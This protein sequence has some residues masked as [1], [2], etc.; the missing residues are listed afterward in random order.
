MRSKLDAIQSDINMIH[1]ND[2]YVPDINE[3][4]QLALRKLGNDNL[5]IPYSDKN[6]NKRCIEY[7]YKG[8]TVNKSNDETW[9]LLQI[10]SRALN[11]RNKDTAS[12]IDL[13]KK[14]EGI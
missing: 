14:L 12:N 8:L 9:L 5:I 13:C 10:L 2:R 4:S 1:K 3:D 11:G 7:F 6:I